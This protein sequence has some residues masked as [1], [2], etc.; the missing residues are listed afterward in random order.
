MSL[1]PYKLLKHNNNVLLFTN[2]NNKNLGIPT[3]NIS[4]F[5]VSTYRWTKHSLTTLMANHLIYYPS[6]INLTYAWSFGSAA[7][8]CLAL[9]STKDRETC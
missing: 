6:P 2:K 8:I 3:L 5:V 4:R 7:G 1:K 9:A